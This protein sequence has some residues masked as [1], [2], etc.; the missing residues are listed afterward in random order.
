MKLT[1]SAIKIERPI[2]SGRDLTEDT[3]RHAA[4]GDPRRSSA[5]S[6]RSDLRISLSACVSHRLAALRIPV[7]GRLRP[8]PLRPVAA[9][10]GA[11]QTVERGEKQLDPVAR[12]KGDPK[13]SD[14]VEAD[15]S[16][17]IEKIDRQSRL[18]AS[19]GAIAVNS[20]RRPSA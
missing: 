10:E 7:L 5:C 8:R 18:P 20:Q 11:G 17:R 16:G 9:R 1:S 12:E 2:T 3:R 6:P 14:S 19:P 15:K 4:L 13:R